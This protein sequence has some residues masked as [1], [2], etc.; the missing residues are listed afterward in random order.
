HYGGSFAALKDAF[1]SF[2]AGVKDGGRVI[3]CADDPVAVEVARSGL[4]GAELETYG[5]AAGADWRVV[6]AR[7][8]PEGWAFDVA[9]QGRRLGSIRLA[10]PGRHNVTNA[11]G[12]LA[13]AAA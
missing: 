8:G 3:A 12:A 10:V 4:N 7:P 1:R 11:L 13:A 6:D 2:V 5:F 9:R